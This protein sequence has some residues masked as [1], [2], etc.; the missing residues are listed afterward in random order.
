MAPDR[1]VEV[2]Y[3]TS[4][5]E[6]RA[7]ESKEPPPEFAAEMEQFESMMAGVEFI[8]LSDPWLF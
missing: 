5:D 2:A 1:Y 8:D 7:D 3:F 4:E 6:A